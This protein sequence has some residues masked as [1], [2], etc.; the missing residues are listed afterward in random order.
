MADWQRQRAAAQ[1]GAPYTTIAFETTANGVPVFP[2]GYVPAVVWNV[3][4][5]HVAAHAVPAATQVIKRML[6]GPSS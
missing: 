6:E 4:A 5:A 1:P 2:P 3:L